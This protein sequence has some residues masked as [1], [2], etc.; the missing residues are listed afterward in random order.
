MIS[1]SAVWLIVFIV[2]IIIECFTLNLVTIWFAVGAL[3]SFVL[4]L[5][6]FS[7]ATQLIIATL[8]SGLSL[9]LLRP[10]TKKL[11]SP[12]ADTN[13]DRLIGREAL[14]IETINN[15]L[16]L[17]QVKVSGLV[18]SARTIDNTIVKDNSIVSVKAIK[19]N[20][21]IVQI[22]EGER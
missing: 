14:V 7:L 9:L 13:A 6:G 17:G 2:F 19:G 21:L 8:S 12:K 20:R 1:S 22:L 11:F 4:S 10:F 5:M 3:I 15:Q 16:E 18:W